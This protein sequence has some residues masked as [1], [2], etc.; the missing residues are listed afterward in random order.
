MV[1]CRNPNFDVELF[2]LAR[3]PCDQRTTSRKADGQSGGS[4][5][6]YPV[7]MERIHVTLVEVHNL[8]MCL[9]RLKNLDA[10]LSEV[11]ARCCETSQ[12]AVIE[13]HRDVHQTNPTRILPELSTVRLKRL[14]AIVCLPTLKCRNAC[15]SWL[16]GAATF[17]L[18]RAKPKSQNDPSDACASRCSEPRICAKA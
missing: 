8:S 11:A 16:I 9:Q 15:N 3:S 10:H 2:N 13:P 7:E 4:V 1:Q 14:P 12:S 5:D 6:S 18:N 17:F